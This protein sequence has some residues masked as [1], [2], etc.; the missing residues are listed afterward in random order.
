MDV[1]R[2]S[3]D[4]DIRTVHPTSNGEGVLRGDLLLVQ[5]HEAIRHEFDKVSCKDSSVTPFRRVIDGRFEGILKERRHRVNCALPAYHVI[6]FH[7]S[8]VVMRKLRLVLAAKE[9]LESSDSTLVSH[10]DGVVAVD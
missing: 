2:S 1:V 8:V 4:V 5:L 3:N 10:M 9:A 6:R 7:L